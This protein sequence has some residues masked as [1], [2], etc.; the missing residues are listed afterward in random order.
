MSV[1]APETAARRRLIALLEAEFDA[2]GVEV[3]SDRLLDAQAQ[4]R[5]MAG[6]YPGS[7][8]ENGRDGLVL[9]TTIYVQIF[10]QWDNNLDPE[11]IVDPTAIEEW[12][13]RLRRAVRADID[14]NPGDEHLWFFRITKVDYPPDPSGNIS[15]LLATIVT[16]AQNPAL[17]E[18]TD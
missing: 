13:E 3:R 10:R 18:T 7:A 5:A 8:G 11:Q 16:F 15:R 17:V 1:T 4:D 2:D 6:V 14:V 12:A 9:D